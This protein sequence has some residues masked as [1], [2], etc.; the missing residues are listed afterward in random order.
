MKVELKIVKTLN[1]M[2]LLEW[3]LMLLKIKLKKHIINLLEKPIQI[4]LVTKI[5]KQKKSFKKLD[6]HIKSLV[7][8][9]FV[10]NM[11][12]PVKKV[13]KMLKQWIP[14]QFSK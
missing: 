13:S 12:Y 4:K 7:T 8:T 10:K 9:N 11:I 6:M 3:N 14:K 2:M 5:R 1:C